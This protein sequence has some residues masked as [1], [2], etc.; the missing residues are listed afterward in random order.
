M[1]AVMQLCKQDKHLS[2]EGI[3]HG[4]V[5]ALSASGSRRSTFARRRGATPRLV[6]AARLSAAGRRR[7]VRVS[8]REVPRWMRRAACGRQGE[9]QPLP[10][11]R[12]GGS[13]GGSRSSGGGGGRR[14]RMSLAPPPRQLHGWR[15][16]AHPRC[17]TARVPGPLRRVGVCALARVGFTPTPSLIGGGEGWLRQPMVSFG[18]HPSRVASE[19]A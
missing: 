3:P 8:W 13:G 12:I 5:S 19:S 6:T 4:R 11:I 15:G 14:F 18:F 2:M 9:L 17:A 7:L 10:S 1:T 16:R